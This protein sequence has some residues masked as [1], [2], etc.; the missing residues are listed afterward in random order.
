MLIIKVK[1]GE[2]IDKSLKQ[3]KRKFMLTGIS[4]E[5]YE[6]S[7]FMKPSLKRRNQVKKAKYVQKLRTNEDKA[8]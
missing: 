5:L 4:N 6:R 7:Q 2:N 3:L 8:L 1:P